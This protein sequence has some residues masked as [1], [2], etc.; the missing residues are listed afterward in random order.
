MKYAL[1]VAPTALPPMCG[2]AYARVF[3][4]APPS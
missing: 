4:P 3:T 1:F 2:A